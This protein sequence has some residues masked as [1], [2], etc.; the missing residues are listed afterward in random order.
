MT[1]K[2]SHLM[3]E[4]TKSMG[5]T[6]RRSTRCCGSKRW[7]RLPQGISR[8][9]A[10][11]TE[12]LGRVLMARRR[13]R[14]TESDSERDGPA[15]REQQEQTLCSDVTFLEWPSLIIHTEIADTLFLLYFSSHLLFTTLSYL[16]VYYPSLT[17]I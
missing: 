17:R 7:Q 16:F 1:L 5:S 8:S 12:C 10:Q 11:S 2:S 13:L 6:G 14:W 4:S 9:S 15:W 3:E